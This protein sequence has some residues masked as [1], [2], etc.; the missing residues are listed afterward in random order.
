MIKYHLAAE[1]IKVTKEMLSEY[2]LQITEDSLSLSK[3]EKLI[4]NLGN[5]NDANFI[6]KT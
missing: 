6:I 5:K 1:K 2:Q 4:P 3:N